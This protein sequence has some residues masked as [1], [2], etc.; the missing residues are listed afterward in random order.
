MKK[1]LEQ[2]LREAEK[3]FKKTNADINIEA[4]NGS[5]AYSEALE[6]AL[7]DAIVVIDL[8]KK[9]LRAEKRK[10]KN[11]QNA[12]D[13]NAEFKYARESFNKIMIN[14]GKGKSK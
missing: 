8:Y 10:V 9:A 2:Q 7:T 13:W 3:Q 12:L 11:Y 14:D 4:E 1:T 6:C 5:H